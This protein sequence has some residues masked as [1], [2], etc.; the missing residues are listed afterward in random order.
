VKII[1]FE[2]F[3]GKKEWVL[4]DV[5]SFIGVDYTLLPKDSFEAH[6]RSSRVPRFPQL[7][8]LKNRFLPEMGNKHYTADLPNTPVNK[9]LINVS[10]LIHKAHRVVNPLIN[11]HPPVMKKS[12]EEFLDTYFKRE[13]K[14]I[15]E[16]LGR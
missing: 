7:Q 2:E 10:Q 14:G 5:C 3:L 8:A 4:E 6:L 16:L 12:T 11:A 1:I 9:K 15:N 13:L